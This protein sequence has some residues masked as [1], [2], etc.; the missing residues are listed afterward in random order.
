MNKKALKTTV[1]SLALVGAIGVGATLAYLSSESNKLTNTFTVGEGYTPI[2][3]YDQALILH[4][5]SINPKECEL[6]AYGDRTLCGNEYNNMVAG[7]IVT[8]DPEITLNKNSADSYLYMVVE[9]LDELNVKKVTT[10][11]NTENWEKI[12]R[13]AR[14]DGIYRYKGKTNNYV[15]SQS[16]EFTT[17]ALFEKL[18]FD[19]NVDYS[20]IKTLPKVKLAAAAVQATYYEDAKETVVPIAT[21]DIEAR[22][23]LSDAFTEQ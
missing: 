7:S 3:G 9:G 21:A 20:E 15:P 6:D 12:D 19:G 14:L 5:K 16:T 23:V 22:K 1:A 18:Y 4:E 13:T 2:P 11:I 10:T 8:K 17:E